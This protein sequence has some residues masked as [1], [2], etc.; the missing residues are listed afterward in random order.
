[1]AH[2]APP[3]PRRRVIERI[4]GTVLALFGILL[5]VFAL[6]ALKD[7]HGKPTAKTTPTVT[8]SRS[9]TSSA[10][11][12]APATSATTSHAPA[13]SARPKPSPTLAVHPIS[14]V[15]LSNTGD[16]SLADTA[17]G[18]F[19]ANGWKIRSTGTFDGAILSSVAYYDPSFPGAQ[20]EALKLQTQ[21]PGLQRVK[22]KFD[23]LPDGPIIVVL[24]SDYS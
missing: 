24:T 15:V 12:P 18:R 19:R 1:V 13:S 21:F 4:L 17:A 10:S 5:V 2:T 11:V 23:G 22:E 14:L 16:I 6:V 8:S 7:P 20:Q 3:S 9:T